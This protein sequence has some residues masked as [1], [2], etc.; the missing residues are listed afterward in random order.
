MTGTGVIAGIDP[1][2]DPN[3]DRNVANHAAFAAG[4]VTASAMTVEAPM[5]AS[6][7]ID[8]FLIA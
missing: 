2:K 6:S 7:T 8:I 4:T 5:R 1:D 3:A